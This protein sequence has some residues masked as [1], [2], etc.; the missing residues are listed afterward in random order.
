MKK[1]LFILFT[2]LMAHGVYS[3]GNNL[4]FN[5]VVNQDFTAIGNGLN[6]YNAG[7][8][9]VGANKVLK[10]TAYMGFRGTNNINYIQ[11]KID[12]KLIYAV[13][14]TND[15]LSATPIWLSSGTHT[16]YLTGYSSSN[17][18]LNFSISGVE[19]NIVN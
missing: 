11:A 6:W 7:T 17:Q 4:Q 18:D 8:I 5:Q 14:N 2:F 9:T 19:F 10:I 13:A 3:Q 16:I 12:N 1:L 15:L